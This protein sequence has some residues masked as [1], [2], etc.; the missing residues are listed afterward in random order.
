MSKELEAINKVVNYWTGFIDGSRR[1]VFDNGDNSSKGAMYTILASMSQPSVY[2]KTRVVKFRELLHKTVSESKPSTISVDYSPDRLL[3]RVAEETLENNY[4][5]M[6]TFP[7]KTTMWINY[8]TGVVSVSEGYRA[9]EVYI[10][11]D[12]TKNLSTLH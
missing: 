2:D 8:D 9:D 7:C 5:P 12:G 1:A 4:N 6:S 10:N 11:E 3:D